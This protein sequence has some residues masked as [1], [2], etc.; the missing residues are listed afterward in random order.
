[1]NR[2]R[3]TTLLSIT[4]GAILFTGAIMPILSQQAFAQVDSQDNL[5]NPPWGVNAQDSV[6]VDLTDSQFAS[7]ANP[8]CLT[9]QPAGTFIL[10]NFNQGPSSFTLHAT[11]PSVTL[12]ANGGGS[13]VD[14]V[15]T[16]T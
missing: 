15:S 6:L 11:V 3:T 7:D 13:T 5:T 16:T 4:L 14:I 2:S 1:M 12:L 10:Q 9:T 8:S